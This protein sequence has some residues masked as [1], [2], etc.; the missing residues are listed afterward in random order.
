MQSEV[1]KCAKLKLE[2]Q[3]LLDSHSAISTE[4]DALR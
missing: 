3:E 2:H 4:L 1:E